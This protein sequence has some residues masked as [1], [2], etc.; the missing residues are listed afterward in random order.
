MVSFY[1]MVF[2]DDTVYCGGMVPRGGMKFLFRIYY[3]YAN[4]Y[5]LFFFH[6]N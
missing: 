6:S 1:D 4:F 2:R 3:G 5:G